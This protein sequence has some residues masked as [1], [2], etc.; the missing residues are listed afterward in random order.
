MVIHMNRFRSLAT[1]ATLAFLA[2]T[3]LAEPK[4]GIAMHGEPGLAA[5]FTI[6]LNNNAMT[7]LDFLL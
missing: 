3:A 5:D 2:T 6:Q 4:H 7:A 1:L